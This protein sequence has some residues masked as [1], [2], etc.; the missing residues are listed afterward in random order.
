MSPFLRSVV[1]ATALVVSLIDVAVIASTYSTQS[2]R[3]QLEAVFDRANSG[4]TRAYALAISPFLAGDA[5]NYRAAAGASRAIVLRFALS[6]PEGHE[7]L[8]V[9]SQASHAAEGMRQVATLLGAERASEAI[10]R[11]NIE[12]KA[13]AIDTT[14]HAEEFDRLA[15][16]SRPDLDRQ[17][18]RSRGPGGSKP[19]DRIGLHGS[20]DH[21]QVLSHGKGGPRRGSA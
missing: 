2:E 9:P 3:K 19:G 13:L 20:K 8:P 12:L 18:V 6:P 4:V 7:P 16:G 17:P 14:N 21:S 10:K 11:F 15:Q 5:L 1:F